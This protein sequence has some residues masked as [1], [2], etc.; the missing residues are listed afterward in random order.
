VRR[1]KDWHRVAAVA[2]GSGAKGE[3]RCSE[4]DGHDEW[5]VDVG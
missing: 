3:P 2:A 5:T 4:H 1:P